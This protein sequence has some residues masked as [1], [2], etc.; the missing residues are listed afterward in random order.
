MPSITK[1][2]AL[3]DTIKTKLFSDYSNSPSCEVCGFNYTEKRIELAERVSI[4]VCNE[5]LLGIKHAEDNNRNTIFE[6]IRTES[7]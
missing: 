4:V 1:K 3:I 7:I 6:I 2:E 5:C